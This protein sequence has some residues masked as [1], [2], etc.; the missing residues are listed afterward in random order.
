MSNGVGGTGWFTGALLYNNAFYNNGTA[1]TVGFNAGI[2]TVTLSAN[3]YTSIGSD[4]SLNSTAGGGAACKGAGW[5]GA[6]NFGGTGHADIGPLQASGAVTTTVNVIAPT[7]IRN[8]V[9]EG[10]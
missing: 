1:P 2:G 3:P 4:F 8:L 5:P 9:Y 10:E 6:L 7:Q